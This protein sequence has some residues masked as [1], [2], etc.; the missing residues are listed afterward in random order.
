MYI[1][2]DILY[3][4]IP[5]SSPFNEQ[6]YQYI[7]KRDPYALKSWLPTFRRVFKFYGRV[8]KTPKLF[9]NFS[10]GTVFVLEGLISII[11][12][13]IFCI[14]SNWSMEHFIRAL[15]FSQQKN[16]FVVYWM[17][18]VY[19]IVHRNILIDPGYQ[20]RATSG[21]SFIKSFI[22]RLIQSQILI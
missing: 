9:G 11:N 16:I 12:V 5:R 22:L 1:S 8:L 19:L 14:L 2:I 13:A 20:M 17:E 18:K 4:F 21:V 7:R 15:D 3:Y 6:Y 10:F